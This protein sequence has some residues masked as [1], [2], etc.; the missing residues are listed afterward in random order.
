MQEIYSKVSVIDI[1]EVVPLHDKTG[2]YFF[3]RHKWVIYV[4]KER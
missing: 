4:V 3:S 2:S 1:Y